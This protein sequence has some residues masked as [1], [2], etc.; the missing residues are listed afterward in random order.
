MK[1]NLI[2]SGLHFDLKD[3]HKSLVAICHSYKSP[4]PSASLGCRELQNGFHSH[5]QWAYVTTTDHVPE[6]IYLGLEE[7]ASGRFHF[8]FI[9][10]QQSEHSVKINNCVIS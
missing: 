7:L 4:H 2:L 8:Q 5:C 6:V 10:L 9:S 1:N 3:G